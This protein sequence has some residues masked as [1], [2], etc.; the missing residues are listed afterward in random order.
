MLRHAG[1]AAIVLSGVLL[2]ACDRTDGKQRSGQPGA[3]G[4][5][6]RSAGAIT[7]PT[8][9]EPPVFVS[10]DREGKRL[11]S[12]TRQFYQKR[13]GEPAWIDGRKPRRQMDE[14]IQVLQRTDREG[15]DPVLYNASVLSARRVEAGRGFLT[16]KGFD[17]GEAANLDVWLTYLYLQ[18]AS[19]LTSG[20]GGLSHQ[21]PSWR[22]PEKKIDPVQRLEQALDGNQVARSLDAL[23]PQHAQY[24]GLRDA[25]AKYREIEQRGG[26]PAVPAPLKVKP[27]QQNPA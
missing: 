3:V 27:G 17:E 23:T 11:W 22:I 13:G 7:I 2:V 16:V 5:A 18:Y 20:V 9:G 25:L 6:G 26:W 19:D 12:L 1:A 4:T 15:L 21:D 10:R 14:L 24:T 8:A